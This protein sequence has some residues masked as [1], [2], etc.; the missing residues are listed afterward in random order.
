MG[1]FARHRRLARADQRVEI[2]VR[3]AGEMVLREKLA[4]HIHRHLVGASPSFRR[5]PRL[6]LE[7][8]NKTREQRGRISRG[9]RKRESGES[10]AG[11]QPKWRRVVWENRKLGARAG[12]WTRPRKVGV[13]RRVVGRSVSTRQ[14]GRRF[15]YDDVAR[16]RVRGEPL[17]PHP[18][19]RAEM[20][21]NRASLARSP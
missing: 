16:V 3:G 12:S 10:C 6:T 15:E 8:A 11:S 9:H 13:R 14:I 21:A 4:V 5:R 18:R 2:D 7:Q 19:S 20:P 1:K 17:L